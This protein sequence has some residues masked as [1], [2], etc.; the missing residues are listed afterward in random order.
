MMHLCTTEQGIGSSR[1]HLRVNCTYAV[2]PLHSSAPKT[3]PRNMVVNVSVRGVRLV[4]RNRQKVLGKTCIEGLA[5]DRPSGSGRDATAVP[6]WFS[7]T[8]KSTL[9]VPS[10]GTDTVML[11]KYLASW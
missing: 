2:K 4:E 3:Y 7:P 9:Y 8:N 5:E 1:C 6:R 10:A 11:W